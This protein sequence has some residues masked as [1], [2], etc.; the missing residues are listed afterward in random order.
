MECSKHENK[1]LVTNLCN[2]P[3]E[4]GAATRLESL[5]TVV[6]KQK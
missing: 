2:I 3:D 6:K 4:T 5:T 1:Q